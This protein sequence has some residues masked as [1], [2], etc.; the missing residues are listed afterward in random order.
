MGKVKP[1]EK[2]PCGSTKK[3]KKCCGL[4]AGAGAPGANAGPGMRQV[5]LLTNAVLDMIGKG[6][7]D[8]VKALVRRGL[9]VNT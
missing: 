7:V 2:C 9:N 1:N 4:H 6:D 5:P 3:Y 8:A